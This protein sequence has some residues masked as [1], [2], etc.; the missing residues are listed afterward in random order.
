MLL[1]LI[2][3]KWLKLCPHVQVRKI[4]GNHDNNYVFLIDQHICYVVSYLLRFVWLGIV[5]VLDI[6]DVY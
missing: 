3:H 1:H 6:D 4:T 2:W 5:T